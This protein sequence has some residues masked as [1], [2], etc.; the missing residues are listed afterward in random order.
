MV[1]ASERYVFTCIILLFRR[2]V[3][4]KM[5]KNLIKG[6]LD[7]KRPYRSGSEGMALLEITASGGLLL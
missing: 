5:A 2:I 7:S 1:I 3:K 4:K 6:S